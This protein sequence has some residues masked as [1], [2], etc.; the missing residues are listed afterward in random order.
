MM[1]TAKHARNGLLCTVML[2]VFVMAANVHLTAAP[3]YSEGFNLSGDS[4]FWEIPG[5]GRINV[6]PAIAR[7]SK[8]SKPCQQ[9][10]TFESFTTQD[11]EL[12]CGFIF[13]EKPEEA[14]LYIKR[15]YSHTEYTTEDTNATKNL[16]VQLI[17]GSATEEACSLG[18][19]WNSKRQL[20]SD[21]NRSWV[22]CYNSV[23]NLSGVYNFSY[24][25]TE[26][27][28][29]GAQV[30]SPAWDDTTSALTTGRR[31]EG[32]YGYTTKTF[33]AGSTTEFMIAYRPNHSQ[34][35][36]AEGR[37][38]WEMWC[39]DGALDSPNMLIKL[40]PWSEDKSEYIFYDSGNGWTGMNSTHPTDGNSLYDYGWTDFGVGWVSGAY[41]DDGF[42][43]GNQSIFL[44]TDATQ[45]G[46]GIILGQNTDLT[47]HFSWWDNT[48]NTTF[49]SKICLGYRSNGGYLQDC[50]GLQSTIS[51][52]YYTK[53]VA[54]TST[55]T[56]T[57]RITGWNNWTFEMNSTTNSINISMNGIKVYDF[58][59]WPRMN[60]TFFND[61]SSGTDRDEWF[62]D[63]ACWNGSAGD[64]PQAE[65]DEITPP[66][67][68][69]PRNIT[70]A[71]HKTTDTVNLSMNWSD[72]SGIDVVLIEG[73]WSGGIN[74]TAT[75]QS[76]LWNVTVAGLAAGN[77]RWRSIAN[78]TAGN[79]NQ[80]EWFTFNIP[81]NLAVG[82]VNLTSDDRPLN[83]TLG[84]L[85]AN[86]T[87]SDADNDSISG[88]EI[89]WQRNSVEMPLLNDSLVLHHANTTRSQNWTALVRV[90]DGANWSTWANQTL[91]IQNTPPAA[92][93]LSSPA[94][95]SNMTATAVAFS[96]TAP[97][98]DD[99]DTLNY[100]WWLDG[101]DKHGDITV[102]SIT[103]A[104]EA[105]FH[106]WSV[107]A[108]DGNEGST[109]STFSFFQEANSPPA[110]SSGGGGG[111]MALLRAT[112]NETTA[113]VSSI[114][115][116][117]M[118]G[119]MREIWQ[120]A[121]LSLSTQKPTLQIDAS[122]EQVI[123]FAPPPIPDAVKGIPA[124]V[125]LAGFLV[126]I[127]ASLLVWQ[128]AIQGILMP[129]VQ[130]LGGWPAVIVGV[131]I[132]VLAAWVIGGG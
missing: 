69:D 20:I 67:W 70:P 63:V 26:R 106:N 78:D 122:G 36:D 85:T 29:I 52:T 62:D 72:A 58:A 86:Y 95:G 110:S 27:V 47:C 25:T 5:Q 81:N 60:L 34:S 9:I 75:N 109:N 116:F 65:G 71:S 117:S 49:M 97:V 13:E 48:S 88:V 126:A 91:L 127:V 66:S 19:K 111:G 73:N 23:Q 132:T 105:G 22:M 68:S 107:M 90:N 93:A 24:F 30:I 74:Y 114:K 51:T 10:I 45:E 103:V 1:L 113:L 54:G 120:W 38:K 44:S 17:S 87:F 11:K 129:G 101:G 14:S 79:V 125:W 18:N 16:L 61:G 99:A 42:K 121:R 82:V 31:A 43:I 108:T 40:D 53:I 57:A 59:S 77:Y 124:A 39:W 83:R 46:P 94:N 128:Y 98:D 15:N 89:R 28:Q 104:I 84:N 12:S 50:V 76:P 3:T 112:Q 92:P 7:C 6:T 130:A 35:T 41:D 4:V 96:W 102:P 33:K 115:A 131:A 21:G 118:K 64:R 80:S 100:T 56:T 2:L 37:R 119:W 32:F 8:W 123:S 55:A